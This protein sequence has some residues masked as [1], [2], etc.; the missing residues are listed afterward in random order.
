LF[1]THSVGEAVR[2]A[3]RII[4]LHAYP[5]RIRREFKV[6]LP[7]PRDFDSREVGDLI[8]LVR[9]EIE[10]EVNRFHAEVHNG[11]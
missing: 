11:H 2:L 1:V 3:D 7:H 8:R 9:Q 5:G 6:D 4:V 10:D